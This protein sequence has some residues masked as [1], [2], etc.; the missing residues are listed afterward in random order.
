MSSEV[1][2]ASQ[3]QLL[4]YRVQ[5][6]KTSFSLLTVLPTQVVCWEGHS[7]PTDV[8]LHFGVYPQGRIGVDW[9]MEASKYSLSF[10]VH[11]RILWIRFGLKVDLQGIDAFGTSLVSPT[12]FPSVGFYAI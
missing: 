10:D 3:S 4:P 11:R 12:P 8:Q 6:P 5:K 7:G 9:T 2:P 1:A